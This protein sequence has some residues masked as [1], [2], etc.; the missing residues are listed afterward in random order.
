MP[1]DLR[2]EFFA[3]LVPHTT[4][5]EW[6][7][8][9]AEVLADTFAT[10][11]AA[12]DPAPD[13]ALDRVRQL[14]QGH[15]GEGCVFPDEPCRCVIPL[16][17]L[18]AALAPTPPTVAPSDLPVATGDAASEGGYNEYA[19]RLQCL[20]SAHARLSEGI[21]AASERIAALYDDSGHSHEGG[22]DD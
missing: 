21:D 18:R 4:D 15:V 13:E 1:D 17:D 7:D 22:G 9:V 16:F 14:D 6:A 3:A 5:H 8:E 19:A 11:L 12:T 20:N 10:R 2:D